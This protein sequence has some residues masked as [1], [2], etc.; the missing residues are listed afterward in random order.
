MPGGSSLSPLLLLKYFCFAPQRRSFGDHILFQVSFSQTES[1]SSAVLKI[2]QRAID[3]L[4]LAKSLTK[5]DNLVLSNGLIMW[6]RGIV[7]F[8]WY[9]H[10]DGA[11][12]LVRAW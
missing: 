1:K 9:I 12:L 8:V 11:T 4:Y 6:N 7:G 10:K 3:S 5:Q 2:Y